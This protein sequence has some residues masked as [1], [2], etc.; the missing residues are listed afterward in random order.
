MFRSLTFRHMYLSSHI[1]SRRIVAL[2]VYFST[3][4]NKTVVYLRIFGVHLSKNSQLRPCTPSRL[5]SRAFNIHYAIPLH[6]S[7]FPP[8]ILRTLP[9]QPPCPVLR[10]PPKTPTQIS[11]RKTHTRTS[12][13]H[14]SHS[15]LSPPAMVLPT[16]AR[17]SRC[18]GRGR[19]PRRV[20][21]DCES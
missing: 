9:S 18:G 1:P 19:G 6:H 3:R 21:P 17:S 2:T 12:H 8:S 5:S 4:T 10:L 20:P 16:P 13:I 14:V 11:P 7:S 15:S